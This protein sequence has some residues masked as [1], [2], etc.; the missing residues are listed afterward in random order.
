MCL[1]HL[2]HDILWPEFSFKELID[3]DWELNGSSDLLAYH[4]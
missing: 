3:K 4:V 2:D 1:D